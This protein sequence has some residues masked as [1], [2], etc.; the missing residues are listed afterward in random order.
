MKTLS[1]FVL[2]SSLL[3]VCCLSITLGVQKTVYALDHLRNSDEEMRQLVTVYDEV[4]KNYVEI[5]DASP[6]DLMEG[7]IVGMLQTL[8]PYSQYFPPRNTRNSMKPPRVSS[9]GWG[10]ASFLHGRMHAG[11]RAG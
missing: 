3:V 8:D 11:C 6:A 7:A 2:V 9:A 1:R 4:L 10:S 5:K